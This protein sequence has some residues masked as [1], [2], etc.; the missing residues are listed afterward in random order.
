MCVCEINKIV[1]VYSINTCFFLM[2]KHSNRVECVYMSMSFTGNVLQA[3]L[4]IILAYTECNSTAAILFLI[5]ATT[6]QGSFSVGTLAS[7]IDISPN[8][9][10]K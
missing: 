3:V 6:V 5:F 10:S 9:A 1:N 2:H 4:V 7:V 8:F